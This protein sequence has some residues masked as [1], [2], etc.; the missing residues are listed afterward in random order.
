MS[1]PDDGD[2]APVRKK[3][4]KKKKP[5]PSRWPLYAGLA[6]GMLAV[7]LL[8][9]W[10]AVK[11]SG[12]AKPLQPVA[13]YERYVTE[14]DEFGFDVPANWKVKAYGTSGKRMI[15][16]TSG[17]AT[18][19]FK[20]NL[21]GSVQGDIAGAG[22]K[23][24]ADDNHS[25]LARVHESRKPTE[26]ATYSEGQAVTVMSKGAGKVRY[27]PYSDGGKR[28]YRATARLG[29]TALDIYC[30]CSPADWE[31]LR[32]AFEHVIESVGR[33]S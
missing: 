4:K 26:S 19:N 2:D 5:P 28:G 20:E 31:T 25:P 10:A 21:V 11:F 8:L 7:S 9:I 12:G 17:S 14:Q 18:I 23:F 1:N 3:K 13:D 22:A 27:S 32:P 33:G 15:E 24:D 16:V 6:G 30:D 29:P